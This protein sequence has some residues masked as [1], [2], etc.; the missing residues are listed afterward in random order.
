MI[1]WSARSS[2]LDT[3]QKL[4]EEWSEESGATK[5]NLWECLPVG[6]YHI[7]NGYN[8]RTLRISIHCEAVAH[9]IETHVSRDP[10][11]TEEGE[12]LIHIVRFDNLS[13]VPNSRFILIALSKIMQRT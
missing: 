12:G 7:L 4:F 10:T 11:K 9:S 1:D 8:V 6:S 5:S 13:N 2:R 3:C